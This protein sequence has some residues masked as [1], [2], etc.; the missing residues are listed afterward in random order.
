MRNPLSIPV[1][2]VVSLVEICAARAD[3]A[4]PDAE[5]Q[6][7]VQVYPCRPTIA[8]TAELVPA[9]ALEIETGYAQRRVD[10]A[11]NHSV[12]A[13]AKYS[14]TDRVQLQV[15]TNNL[16]AAQSGSGAQLIDGVWFGP[17]VL[18][19]RQDGYVPSIAV[20]AFLAVPTRDGPGALTQSKDADMW[21]YASKDLPLGIHADLNL[22]IDVLGVDDHPAI[23]ELVAL[24]LSR[25]LGHGFGTMLEGYAFEG[26]GTHAE[27]DAGVLTGLTFAVVPRVM[28]DA[29]F[30]VALYRDARDVTMFAGVT[31]VPY[32]H[33]A[34][35]AAARVETASR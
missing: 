17:K 9:G 26:G 23:Q 8:C 3:P 10:G 30:D 21:V 2:V 24:S 6:G 12:Q 15:A 4:P 16:I 32:A 19:V 29:G 22:G 27:H 18:L 1:V 28:L 14:V 35:T 13:L 5:V 31:F 11:P 25:D 33:A 7:E 34:P 20:S